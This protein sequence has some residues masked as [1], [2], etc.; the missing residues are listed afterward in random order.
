MVRLVKVCS[1]VC[2]FLFAVLEGEGEGARGDGKEEEA[3]VNRRWRPPRAQH[4]RG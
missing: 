4:P 3:D 2:L 1:F